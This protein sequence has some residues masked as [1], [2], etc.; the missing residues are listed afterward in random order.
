[1]RHDPSINVSA[2]ESMNEM[3]SGTAIPVLKNNEKFINLPGERPIMGRIGN[4]LSQGQA[5]Q[6]FCSRVGSTD[7]YTVS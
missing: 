3:K 1:M 4:Q 7:P 2:N 6:S 5:P